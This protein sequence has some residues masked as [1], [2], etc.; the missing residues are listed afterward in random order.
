MDK[1]PS[2]KNAF[3]EGLFGM[4]V[5][6]PLVSYQKET[7]RIQQFTLLAWWVCGGALLG[8][9]LVNM[10]TFHS[11][12]LY[13]DAF[14]YGPSSMDQFFSGLVELFAQSNFYPLFAFLF[15]YGAMI[16]VQRSQVKG[17]YFPSFLQAVYRF[18]SSTAVYT[19]F[20]F[21]MAIF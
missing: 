20:S 2:Q 14:K 16:I 10:P 13:L 8:I 5:F 19:P 11:P 6:R 12:F 21:G 4:L 1:L 18:C 15:G 17:I 3:F 7:I 9:L